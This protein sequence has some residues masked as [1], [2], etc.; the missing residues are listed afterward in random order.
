MIA[1]SMYLKFTTK[2]QGKLLFS[3][4]SSPLID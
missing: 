4:Q 3:N 2:I 1:I